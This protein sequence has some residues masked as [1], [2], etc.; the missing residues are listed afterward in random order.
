M[1][2]RFEKRKY[3]PEELAVLDAQRDRVE[4]LNEALTDR[5]EVA[6]VLGGSEARGFTF[7]DLEEVQFPPRAT[8]LARGD[9]PILRAGQLAQVFA[10]RGVGKTWLTRTLAIVMASRGD[11]L[12]FHA[13][14]A[15]RE[16]DG[17]EQHHRARHDEDVVELPMSERSLAGPNTD[18]EECECPDQSQE[19]KCA[20]GAH[21]L[22]R[23]RDT[24]G[25]GDRND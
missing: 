18:R 21:A 10:V 17:P 15:S 19:P 6:Q 7:G 5:H 4:E 12:G 20:D 9:T 3:T 14:V 22:E 23:F 24:E 1:S 13:P 25:Q 16:A 2:L 11:A 8:L